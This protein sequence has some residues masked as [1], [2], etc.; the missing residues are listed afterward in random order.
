MILSEALSGRFEGH[1]FFQAFLNPDTIAPYQVFMLL[2]YF[3]LRSALLSSQ[4]NLRVFSLLT[5]TSTAAS[6][7]E[8]TLRTVDDAPGMKDQDFSL[9]NPAL[10]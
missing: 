7:V 8:I 6:V 5:L 4:T 9:D 1:P 2:V 10:L 3:I